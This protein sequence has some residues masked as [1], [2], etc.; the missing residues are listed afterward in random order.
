M[1]SQHH[2][3]IALSLLAITACASPRLWAETDKR[4]LQQQ[5][6]QQVLAQPLDSVEDASLSKALKEAAERG[7]PSKSKTQ[8]EYYQY[9]HNGYYYPYAAYRLGYWY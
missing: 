8:T 9:L 7:Q 4:A 2:K 1:S 5:L 3:A 6:N